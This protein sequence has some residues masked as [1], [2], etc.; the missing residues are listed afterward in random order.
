MLEGLSVGFCFPTEARGKAG[1][2]VTGRNHGASVQRVRA[3][4][5]AQSQGLLTSS[6]PEHRASL[7]VM[8]R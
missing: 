7:C 2:S 6:Q 3:W 4:G 1:V 5:L 8:F